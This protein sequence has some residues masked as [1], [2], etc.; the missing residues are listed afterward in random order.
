[1]LSVGSS[2]E[3]KISMVS[4]DDSSSDSSSGVSGS[5]GTIIEESGELQLQ[6]VSKKSKKLHHVVS[7]GQPIATD[8][9]VMQKGRVF[10]GGTVKDDQFQFLI[11]EEVTLAFVRNGARTFDNPHKLHH[12]KLFNKKVSRF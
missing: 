4:I 2:S 8:P 11:A 12:R 3:S 7:G 6:A 9:K 10:L 1:M 5:S